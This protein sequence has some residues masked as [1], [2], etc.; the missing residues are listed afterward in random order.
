[1]ERL[2]TRYRDVYSNKLTISDTTG[3]EI[4]DLGIPA[5]FLDDAKQD[6]IYDMDDPDDMFLVEAVECVSPPPTKKKREE[7]ISANRAKSS[8]GASSSCAAAA[9]S[10]DNEEILEYIQ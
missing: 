5:M 9:L 6:D 3:S 10:G 7:Q 8:T 4:D 2:M 1:M